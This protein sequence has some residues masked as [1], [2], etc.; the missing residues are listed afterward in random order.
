MPTGERSYDARETCEYE[1]NPEAHPAVCCD[2]R[3]L[4]L[5]PRTSEVSDEGKLGSNFIKIDF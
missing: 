2:S 1:L 3:V 4:S 5:R